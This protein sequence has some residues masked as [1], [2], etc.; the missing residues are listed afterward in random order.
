MR[1]ALARE[2]AALE[3]SEDP[4]DVEH[5]QTMIMA[6]NALHAKRKAHSLA[7]QRRLIQQGLSVTCE[8]KANT[9]KGSSNKCLRGLGEAL[10]PVTCTCSNG[11]AATGLAC[12][13]DGAEM[14]V[15]CDAGYFMN[16]TSLPLATG[17]DSRRL[18]QS[19]TIMY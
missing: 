13:T 2:K 18:L 8:N 16:G 19:S 12:T 7:W 11:M 5:H 6:L 10:G 9:R 3:A 4:D 1:K 15:S 17:A 14:C